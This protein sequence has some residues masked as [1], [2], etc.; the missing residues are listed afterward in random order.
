M[1]NGTRWCHLLPEWKKSGHYPP[2]QRTYDRTGY[3]SGNRHEPERGQQFDTQDYWYI[4]RRPQR[5]LLR[6][7]PPVKHWRRHF[8]NLLFPSSYTPSDNFSSN[9]GLR[10]TS[11]QLSTA[12]QPSNPVYFLRPYLQYVIP[13]NMAVGLKT[14][15]YPDTLCPD[16]PAQH[17]G[18]VSWLHNCCGYKFP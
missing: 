11:E 15:A 9:Q 14:A 4:E 8:I 13:C 7:V 10:A 5:F 12:D 3:R 16:R 6:L 1:K 18:S 2:V 17:R